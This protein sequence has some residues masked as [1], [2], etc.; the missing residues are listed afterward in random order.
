MGGGS[1]GGRVGGGDAGGGD[2]GDGGRGGSDG[3][4]GG[5][6]GLGR[7]SIFSLQH[8]HAHL[9]NLKSSLVVQEYPMSS[10]SHKHLLIEVG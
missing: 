5:G 9:L 4:D 2:G 8:D 1:D 7:F 3:G 10:A 6:G